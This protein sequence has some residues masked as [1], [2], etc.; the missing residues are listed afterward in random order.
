MVVKNTMMSGVVEGS[1]WWDFNHD[2]QST[3][4][5]R[6]PALAYAFHKRKTWNAKRSRTI[7]M[8][9][10]TTWVL[11]EMTDAESCLRTSR[12]T[13]KKA[14]ERVHGFSKKKH[15]MV[16]GERSDQMNAPEVKLVHHEKDD[17]RS[18]HP[19]VKMQESRKPNNPPRRQS[20]RYVE[21]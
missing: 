14:A 1:G 3:T 7:T 15:V 16:R 17:V 13:P 2:C 4:C 18:E 5:Q 6:I 10:P 19:A 21:N 11:I 12:W 20:I 9:N 8:A